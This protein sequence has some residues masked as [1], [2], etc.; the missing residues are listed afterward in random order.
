MKKCATSQELIAR[1]KA[2]SFLVRAYEADPSQKLFVDQ[3]RR[4]TDAAHKWLQN[5]TRTK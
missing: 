5:Q 1:K 2:Y 3:I 4:D